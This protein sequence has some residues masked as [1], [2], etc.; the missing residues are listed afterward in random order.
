MA[1]SKVELGRLLAFHLVVSIGSKRDDSVR[2]I[3]RLH[4]LV[5]APTALEF[6]SLRVAH[7]EFSFVLAQ[8][9]GEPGCVSQR[10]RIGGTCDREAMCGRAGR[11]AQAQR[12]DV[13]GSKLPAVAGRFTMIRL[14]MN[15]ARITPLST[16]MAQASLIRS[17]PRLPVGSKKI[18]FR[19]WRPS[20]Q[21]R[22]NLKQLRHSPPGGLM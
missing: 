12:I 19:S 18:G 8:F 16:P 15:S 7:A 11:R 10:F 1:S 3:E 17:R 14:A 9:F 2:G 13:C 22:L 5:E 20:A 6:T 21:K 4:A